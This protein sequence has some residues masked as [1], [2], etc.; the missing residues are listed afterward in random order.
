M[1]FALTDAYS[2]PQKRKS[3]AGQ[4]AKRPA[5][6]AVFFYSAIFSS[7]KPLRAIF[8]LPRDFS[9]LISFH[10]LGIAAWATTQAALQP[11]PNPYS[12]TEIILLYIGRE[13]NEAFMAKVPKPIDFP[14]FSRILAG[15]LNRD[16][17]PA[18]S[19]IDIQ[20][21]LASLQFSG[22]RTS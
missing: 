12:H 19:G 9:E 14:Y 11:V 16:P 8:R 10:T 13:V 4:G 7:S 21:H 22:F 18:H 17:H 20:I 1:R 15:H 6:V 2:P 3:F 5:L